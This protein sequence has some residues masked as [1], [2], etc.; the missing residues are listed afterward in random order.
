MI[1]G[2]RPAIILRRS[3]VI[4]LGNI[5]FVL[6]INGEPMWL[7]LD[8]ETPVKSQAYV[9]PVEWWPFTGEGVEPGSLTE[10]QAMELWVTGL[11][12]IWRM[13]QCH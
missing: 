3:R 8:L 7:T 5:A 11:E 12:K 10:E 9:W 2:Y 13:R 4:V 6:T 1:L